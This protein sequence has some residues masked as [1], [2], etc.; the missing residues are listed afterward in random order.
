MTYPVSSSSNNYGPNVAASSF[1][2]ELSGGIPPATGAL[3]V[4]QSPSGTSVNS[5]GRTQSATQTKLSNQVV[6]NAGTTPT[7][8]GLLPIFKG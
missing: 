5:T 4:P 1:T 3:A 8:T 6:L 2:Y 7:A